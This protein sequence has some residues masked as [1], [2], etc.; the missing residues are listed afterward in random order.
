LRMQAGTLIHAGS[1]GSLLVTLVVSSRIVFDCMIQVC[2][3]HSFLYL[4]TPTRRVK[5]LPY[6]ASLTVE[7]VGAASTRNLAKQLSILFS[8]S[9]KESVTLGLFVSKK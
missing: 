2:L 3:Q 1:A 4:H 5:C 7:N 6:R 8:G 9:C